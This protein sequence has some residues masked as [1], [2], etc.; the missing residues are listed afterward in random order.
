MHN[1]TQVQ[2]K[3]EQRVQFQPLPSEHKYDKWCLS[4]RGLLSMA[5]HTT[6]S[7]SVTLCGSAYHS[8]VTS[9]ETATST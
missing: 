9:Y 4:S 6:Q 8:R 3:L 1:S 7:I 2:P 5:L